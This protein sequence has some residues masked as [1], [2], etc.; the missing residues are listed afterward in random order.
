MQRLPDVLFVH[1]HREVMRSE[2]VLNWQGKFR[3]AARFNTYKLRGGKLRYSSSL[4]STRATAPERFCGPRLFGER[5]P[6]NGS[7]PSGSGSGLRPKNRFRRASRCCSGEKE[8]PL[9]M[10][11]FSSHRSSAECYANS[12]SA[13]S[14]GS[15]G[16][17]SPAFSPTPTKRTGRPSA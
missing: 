10:I 9:F 6:A 7:L 14:L 11:C 8:G 4:G 16:S 17:R 15:K 5:T 3:H 13:N 1:G 2:R 12:E